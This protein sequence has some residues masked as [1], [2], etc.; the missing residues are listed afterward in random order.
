MTHFDYD[1]RGCRRRSFLLA[2]APFLL[3]HGFLWDGKMDVKNGHSEG[4]GRFFSPA[5]SVGLPP[6]K[7]NVNNLSADGS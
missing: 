5:G 6:L 1:S 3:H 7:G 2:T 4:L